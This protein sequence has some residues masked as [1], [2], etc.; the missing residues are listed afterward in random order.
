MRSLLCV[1]AH[2]VDRY[3]MTYR[4]TET[5]WDLSPHWSGMCEGASCN[6]EIFYDINRVKEFCCWPN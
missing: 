4:D 1:V 2:L 3:G 6:A 5:V